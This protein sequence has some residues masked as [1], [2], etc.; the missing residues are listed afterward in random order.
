MYAYELIQRRSDAIVHQHVHRPEVQ[1]SQCQ[2]GIVV[3]HSFHGLTGRGHTE[4]DQPSSTQAH[5]ALL[6]GLGAE[7]P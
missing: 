1:T 3:H 5:G 4:R 2:T 6:L 7:H